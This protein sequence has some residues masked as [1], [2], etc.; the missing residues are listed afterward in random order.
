[1]IQIHNKHR[2]NMH[3]THRIGLNIHQTFREPTLNIQERDTKVV[4]NI[5]RTYNKQNIIGFPFENS[6]ETRS[7]G[8]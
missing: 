8:L 6:L 4:V 2:L 5:H 1:M 7:Q 3:K